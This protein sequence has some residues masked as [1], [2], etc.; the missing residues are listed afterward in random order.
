[1]FSL[2]DTLKGQKT[3]KEDIMTEALKIPTCSV[4]QEAGN[5]DAWFKS[6]DTNKLYTQ[7]M[8]CIKVWLQ[9]THR[10]TWKAGKPPVTFLSLWIEKHCSDKFTLDRKRACPKWCTVEKHCWL[11]Q[12]LNLIWAYQITY[13]QHTTTSYVNVTAFRKITQ[14]FINKSPAVHRNVEIYAHLKS[15]VT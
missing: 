9:N 14:D 8:E 5:T 6:D 3:H 1:M 11:S 4:P 12:Q 2:T 15:S 13:H 10:F 7:Y